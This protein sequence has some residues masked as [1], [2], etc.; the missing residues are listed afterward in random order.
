M[1]CSSSPPSRRAGPCARWRPI[2]GSPAASIHR[3]VRR[4]TDAG[5]LDTNGRRVNASQAEEFLVHGVKYVFPPVR[6]GETRGIP[7]AWSASPLAGE[8]APTTE[9]PPVWPDPMGEIRGIALQ[10]LHCSAPRSR[11]VT[12]VSPNASRWSTRCAS[13]TPGS[14][15]SPPSCSA[16]GSPARQCPREHRAAR[17]RRRRALEPV[18]DNVVF[19]GG[20]TV[21][22]VDHRSRCSPVRPTKDVDV[23]VEVATRSAFHAFE[24]RLR[25]LRFTEDQT[26][27]IVCRW[28]HRDNDLLLDAMPANP[29][30]L[31]FENRWQALAIP[32]AIELRLPSGARIRAAPPVF[33]LATKIEAFKGRGRGDFLASRDLSDII[34]LV[35]GRAEIV[36]EA[37]E[38]PA[39]LRV[40]LTEE[41]AILLADP[42]F[43]EGVSASLRADVASQ[44]RGD[45]VVL[46]RLRQMSQKVS[47]D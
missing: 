18:L 1:F 31:G 26:D 7:T 15:G 34:A 29:A 13:A 36:G 6:G 45:A 33:L 8:L 25:S 19:L 44:A 11:A 37:T 22:A 42:R 16:S 40:Y 28:R 23:V 41:L 12:P 9:L 10:P 3:S 46:P 14:A 38:A 5:L 27:G 30:I 39:D 43:P 20:A 17:A 32:H 24:E 47:A 35:D 4:L 21:D 2:S